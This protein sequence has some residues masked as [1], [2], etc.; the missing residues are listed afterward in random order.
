MPRLSAVQQGYQSFANLLPAFLS[1]AEMQTRCEA[2]AESKAER[3]EE[4]ELR[5]AIRFE[6]VSFAYDE[7]P[8]LR[9]LNL[10]IRAGETTAIVGPSG[11]GKST[12]ADL[13]TGLI[14]PRAGRVL[15]DAIPLNADRMKSWR[16]QIGYVVQDT[17][18]VHDTI[19]A[20]L[21]WAHPAATEEE[22]HRALTW[23][24][25]EE[26]VAR[27]AE[28]LNT[29][30][31]DRG[32]LLS[33]GER[34]RL[35]LARALLRKPSLLILDEAT[36]TLDS[37]NEQR[38]QRA[39]E[40]LRGRMT[41]LIISHR[42]S[43][44]RNADVIHVLADGRVLESGTWDALIGKEGGRFQSLWRAQSMAADAGAARQNLRDAIST[45]EIH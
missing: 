33:G 28:G 12:I 40:E 34:Q 16:D 25:A 32:V 20:N 35:A 21:L 3:T 7:T 45:E 11:V 5:E 6:D 26:F 39:L 17:F 24:A 37:E 15:V 31:G 10:T 14:E 23:A 42:L 9:D 30:V 1:V 36:S 8:V 22:L 2:A 18:L 27:T 41:I 13:V 19:R 4:I 44:V 29:V 43:T 38:I